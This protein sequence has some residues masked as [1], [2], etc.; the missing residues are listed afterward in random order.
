MNAPKPLPIVAALLGLA[1]LIGAALT[2][3]SSGGGTLEKQVDEFF[4][5]DTEA[6]PSYRLQEPEKKIDQ[7]RSLHDDPA[8][9][10]LPK[11]KQEALQDRLRELKAFQDFQNRLNAISNPKDARN[12]I[13][14]GQILSQLTDLKIPDEFQTEWNQTE[15]ARRHDEWLEDAQALNQAVSEVRDQLQN[16]NQEGT[17]VITNKNAPDLPG[18]ARQV[19]GK[20][21]KS[22]LAEIDSARLIPGSTRVTYAMVLQIAEVEAAYQEWKKV[23]TTLESVSKSEKR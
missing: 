10:K 18:R 1:A 3:S 2:L 21:M 19:L 14:L 13:Q 12:Q 6:E 8:F 9:T 11:S 7:L 23:R 16:L 5:H 17:Q 15:A 20:A 22:R 4:A